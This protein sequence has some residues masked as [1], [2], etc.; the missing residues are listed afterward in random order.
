MSSTFRASLGALAGV[1]G[2]VNMMTISHPLWFRAA[3]MAVSVVSSLIALRVGSG[4]FPL[5]QSAPAS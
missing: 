2:V 1:S 5:A 3:V 4:G